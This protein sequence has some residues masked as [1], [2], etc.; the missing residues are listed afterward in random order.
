MTDIGPNRPGGHI[1]SIP[2][3]YRDCGRN[4]LLLDPWTIGQLRRRYRH[5]RKAGLRP[6]TAR[7]ILW[8][9]AFFVTISGSTFVPGA[10]TA[11]SPGLVT[12]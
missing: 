3:R 4:S 6:V 5:L 9:V 7:S 11:I 8:D 12:A 1:Y 2:R 10:T